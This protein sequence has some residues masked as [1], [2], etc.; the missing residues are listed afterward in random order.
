VTSNNQNLLF[1]NK[2]PSLIEQRLALDHLTCEFAH[3]LLALAP[4]IG[5]AHGSQA[6]ND[7][8]DDPGSDSRAIS[9]LI[10]LI[11]YFLLRD[12]TVYDNWRRGW[13]WIS[14]GKHKWGLINARGCQA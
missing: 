2:G 5:D 7:Q 12:N 10:I 13:C 1:L 8:H 14:V 3:D 9:L 4:Y 11:L 6:Y